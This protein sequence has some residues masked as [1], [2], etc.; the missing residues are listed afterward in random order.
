MSFLV[1]AWWARAGVTPRTSVLEVCIQTSYLCPGKNCLQIATR[2]RFPEVPTTD[3]FLRSSQYGKA[4][5]GKEK[6]LVQS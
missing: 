1:E 5:K 2:F 3:L 4:D 6:C